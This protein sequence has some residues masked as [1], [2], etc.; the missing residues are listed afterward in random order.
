[1]ITACSIGNNGR[2]GNQMFQYA[3]LVGISCHKKYDFYSPAD[4]LFSLFDM[5]NMPREPP[6]FVNRRRISERMFCFDEQLFN[7]L[8]DEVDLF[9]YFQTR[10]Y[11]QHCEKE[12]TEIFTFKEKPNQDTKEICESSCFLHIRRT[13]YLNLP[14][15]HTNLNFDYY[16][17]ALKVIDPKR[18]LIFSDDV[19]WCKNTLCYNLETN[20]EILYANDVSDK[21]STD[22]LLMSLCKDAIIA[23]SSF[24]WWGAY[25]GPQQNNGTIVAP[26]KWFSHRGPQDFQDVYLPNWVTL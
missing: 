10:K 7:Q 9:G 19:Q 16:N 17:E 2:L 23:N 5:K 22:M 6:K 18:L 13:D 11:W 3:A 4:Q 14:D 1:M 15:Y 8:P 20:A 26:K 21:D 24:S 25:L 12:I